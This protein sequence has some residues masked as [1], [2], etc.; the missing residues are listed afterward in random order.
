LSARSEWRDGTRVRSVALT[1]LGG[2]RYRVRVD[3]AEVEVAVEP[4]S[5][6]RLR[7]V[8]RDGGTVVEITRAGDRRFVRLGS[9]DF[10]FDREAKT[11]R[12]RTGAATAGGLESPM[13]GLVTR[14]MVEPGDVVEK[15][16]ALVAVEAMKMEHW[17]RAPRSGRVARVAFGVGQMVNGG[18]A[19]VELEDE[20]PDGA[21]S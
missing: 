19:L 6:R 8:T 9:F 4:L 14:V 13:P 3:D 15:G 10:V 7:L 5:D 12:R 20:P 2:G 17:I 11:G 21:R 1:P 16:Q 18:T